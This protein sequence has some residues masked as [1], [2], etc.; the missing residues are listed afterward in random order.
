MNRGEAKVGGRSIPWS[1]ANEGRRSPG[2]GGVPF[3]APGRPVLSMAARRRQRIVAGAA[4]ALVRHGPSRI[5]VEQIIQAAGI[6]RS[7]F[8]RHFPNRGQ[9]LLVAHE[10]VFRDLVD[11]LLKACAGEPE[12]PGKVAAGVEAAVDFAIERPEEA[13]LLII[14]AVA[15]DAAVAARALDSNEYLAGLL[16]SGRECCER[17]RVLPEVTER[18]LIGAAIGLI[19]SRLLGGRPDR[20]HEL[21]PEL[22]QLFLMPYVSFEEARRFAAAYR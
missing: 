13:H 10:E 11:R 4:Q 22:V 3:P 12:W 16:R 14:D 19:G 15:A 20:L 9:C 18:A 21:V 1:D 6:S 7:T 5:T 8:Y 17:A 2:A